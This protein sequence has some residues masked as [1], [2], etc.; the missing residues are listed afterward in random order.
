[1]NNYADLAERFRLL[2]EK[3]PASPTSNGDT[4]WKRREV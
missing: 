4:D 2:N 3:R 1:M